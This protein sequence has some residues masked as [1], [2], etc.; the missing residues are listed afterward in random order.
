[1]YTVRAGALGGQG[2]LDF[3]ELE[4]KVVVSAQNG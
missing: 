3:L 2:V 1:M 4:L